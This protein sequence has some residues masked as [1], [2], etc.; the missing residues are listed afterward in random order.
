MPRVFPFRA[1][2]FGLAL[3][4]GLSACD[5][6]MSDVPLPEATAEEVSR[7]AA[8][9]SSA[10]GLPAAA[11]GIVSGVLYLAPGL[12]GLT[13]PDDVIF[14]MAREAGSPAAPLAVERLTGNA[15]PLRF[16]LRTPDEGSGKAGPFQIV[17]KV[18]KD[19]DAGTSSADDLLG[20]TPEPVLPGD[21][22]VRVR[23]EASLGQ[24]AAALERE[25]VADS[26]ARSG[27]RPER[28]SAEGGAAISGT[29]ELPEELRARASRGAALF[30]IARAR[31]AAG[32]PFAV[33]R[34]ATDEFPAAFRLTDAD[35][36]LGGPWPRSLEI[37]AR[38]DSDGDPLTRGEGD[39]VGRAP[40]PV[41]PG[42]SAV[43]ILLRDP[44]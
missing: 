23:V 18:D 26:A 30:V 40:A 37:E 35:R 16:T 9:L 41:R 17:V 43:R 14:V 8:R 42:E 22:G 31:G 32:P 28:P 15:Y 36:M 3:L 4:A 11:G 12:E 29:I 33:V 25:G 27:A 13:S 38:L 7:L 1:A 19:G 24:I 6:N 20:F 10:P 2:P 34:L 39:L 5:Q 21:V 44:L